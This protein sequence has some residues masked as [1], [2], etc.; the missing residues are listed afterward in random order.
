MIESERAY[1]VESIVRVSLFVARVRALYGRVILGC[2]CAFFSCSA[3]NF[4]CRSA[5]NPFNSRLHEPNHVRSLTQ[6][7]C[8]TSKSTEEKGEAT[9]RRQTRV[10]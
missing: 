5:F 7:A 1:F 2:I 6:A 10:V 3:I 9:G 4:G 8:A